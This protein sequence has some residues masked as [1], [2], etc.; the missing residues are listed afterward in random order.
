[1]AWTLLLIA[2]LLEPVW[3][4]ALE[5]SDG[6]RHLGF[7]VLGVTVATASLTLLTFALRD[8]PIGTAYAVWV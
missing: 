3:A 7:S 8:L 1:M 2:A 6:F 5:R 4:L